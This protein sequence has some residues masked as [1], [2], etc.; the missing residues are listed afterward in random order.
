MSSL[1]PTRRLRRLRLFAAAA[2]SALAASMLTTVV[3]AEPA[4]AHGNVM[5][6]ASRNQGCLDRWGTNHQAPQMAT[7]DPMCY[8]AWQAD[9]NAMWNW[10]GNLR[11]NVGGIAESNTPNGQLCSNGRA[12][13]PRYNALD[14]VGNWQA[15]N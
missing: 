12:Q 2:V 13:A 15:T 6:P 7:E 5:F 8:Q 14:A 11:D 1:V 3:V 4:A 10:N 9:P